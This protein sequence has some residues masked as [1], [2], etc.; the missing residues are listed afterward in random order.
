MRQDNSASRPGISRRRSLGLMGA[1]VLTACS[2]RGTPAERVV[3]LYN[4][5]DYLSPKLLQDFQARTGIVPRYDTFDSNQTLEAK[6]LA[7]HAGYDVVF[8]S[9]ATLRRLN[10][11]NVFQPLDR[12]R[13]S[14]HANLDPLFLQR[15]TAYDPDNRF[16]IPYA[17]G[18]TGL[19]I[20]IDR[21]R[22]LLPDAPLDGWSLLLDP[23]QV[24]RIAQ[25][26]VGLYDSPT[27]LF[28]S[29]LAWLGLDPTSDDAALLDQAGEALFAVRQ[30]V[31]KFTQGS[32][33]ED[34]ANGELCMVIASDGD[35]RQAKARAHAA[36]R[37][38]DL[39]FVLPRE[40]ATLWFDVAAI[41]A[42]APNPDHALQFIDFLLEADVAAANSQSIGFAN[43]NLAAQAAMPPELRNETL[44]PVSAAASQLFAEIDHGQAYERRRTRWWTRVRTGVP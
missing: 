4:W 24:S 9:A 40:G 29:V 26:G 1:S 31:R 19:A 22:R 12:P 15:L 42:D 28:P 5:Y 11:A 44:Y 14:H 16:S 41:P 35:L 23:A 18:I 27:T 33:V 10:A 2:R 20:D 25:C 3:N 43:A 13:L 21:I 17:W 38:A 7:G 32:L 37:D 39:R 30:H 8:P 34:L 36:G 6:L